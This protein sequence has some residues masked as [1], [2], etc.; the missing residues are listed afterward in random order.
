M[1]VCVFGGWQ[2]TMK[3]AAPW[4]QQLLPAPARESGLKTRGCRDSTGRPSLLQENS[5]P[6]GAELARSPQ[7]QQRQWACRPC[8]T[9]RPFP[10]V[11]SSGVFILLGAWVWLLYLLSDC[12]SFYPLF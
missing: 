4:T 12:T 7:A 8:P 10:P 9:S 3:E 5:R 6:H 1:C 2:G 11:A